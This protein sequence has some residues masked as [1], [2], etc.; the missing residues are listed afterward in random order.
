MLQHIKHLALAIFLAAICFSETAT[1]QFANTT[2]QLPTFRFTQFNSSFSVPD[3]GTINL[4]SIGRRDY[5]PG[6]DSGS[7]SS[8]TASARVLIMKELE[9]DMLS[10]AKPQIRQSVQRQQEV[11]GTPKTQSKADF[12]SRNI[13]RR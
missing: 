10:N 2:I 4:S 9:Q 1:A 12:I 11:N 6:G 8:A 7:Y 3:G 5:L 13:N